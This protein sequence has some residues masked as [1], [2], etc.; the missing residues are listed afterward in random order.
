MR[1]IFVYK[2]HWIK[3]AY[4]FQ[5]NI[6]TMIEYKDELLLI[7]DPYDDVLDLKNTECYNPAKCISM[8]I[9]PS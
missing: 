4:K 6:H 7:R 3:C 9:H 8:Y 5:I 2:T 1:S